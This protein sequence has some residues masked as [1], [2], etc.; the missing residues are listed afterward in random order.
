MTVGV[1]VKGEDGLARCAWGASTPE[2]LSYHDDEWGRPV[3]DEV[4]I[5]EKICL[6]GFQSGL[7]WLTILRKREGFRAAFRGFDPDVVARF[8]DKDVERL[9]GDASIV[10][11]RGKIVATIQ[12]AQATVRMRDKGQSLASL[13]W[14]H[15][16]RRGRTVRTTEEIA[17]STPES[18]ALSS[19]LSAAGFH[20]V[21]PTT[22][23]SA[24]QSLG[25]VNDH[26][27]TCHFRSLCSRDRESFTPPV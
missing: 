14:S 10:R 2:Y 22:V 27:R 25:V 3:A 8:G 12:N 18:K 4:R 11:H 6:E 19:A 7:S 13:V 23:Y 21:G 5:F 9:L 17:S 15:E 20:F 16:P 1:T 24:M 26:V